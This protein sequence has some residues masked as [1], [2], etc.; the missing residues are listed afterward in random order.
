V[1]KVETTPGAAPPPLI[2]KAEL[3]GTLVV[4]VADAADQ[5]LS[6][7]NVQ[8]RPCRREWNVSFTRVTDA[9]GLARIEDIPPGAVDVQVQRDACR[10]ALRTDVELDR[11][12]ATMLVVVLKKST[13]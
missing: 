13:P 8:V 11:R 9:H 7:A 4:R 10:T 6:G 5:P 12:G 1:A 2:V 3:P